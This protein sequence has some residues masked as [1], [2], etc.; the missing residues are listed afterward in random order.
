MET[1]IE[2]LLFLEFFNNIECIVAR[3]DSKVIYERPLVVMVFK[4]LSITARRSGRL[5]KD[6]KFTVNW[7]CRGI[8]KVRFNIDPKRKQSV[9]EFRSYFRVYVTKRLVENAKHQ[10]LSHYER[11]A[12]RLVDKKIPAYGVGISLTKYLSMSCAPIH[13]LDQRG[14][15]KWFNKER[16]VAVNPFNANLRVEIVEEVGLFSDKAKRTW[17]RFTETEL[18]GR[19]YT[20]KRL[21]RPTETE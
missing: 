20:W 18:W 19:D 15:R 8:N 10:L 17:V 9:L 1:N 7:R 11:I 4:G 14:Y 21:Y 3:I 12:R 5:S 16:V 6:I 2:T 13:V